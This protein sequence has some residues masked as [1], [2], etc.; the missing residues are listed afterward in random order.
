MSNAN[1]NTLRRMNKVSSSKNLMFNESHNLCFLSLLTPPCRNTYI[2]LE[3]L[4]TNCSVAEVEHNPAPAYMGWPYALLC[5]FLGY[6]DQVFDEYNA[7]S[8]ASFQVSNL[9]LF[10]KL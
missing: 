3:N 6:D 10:Y 4:L 7:N 5:Q 2:F 8:F 1:F 9:K